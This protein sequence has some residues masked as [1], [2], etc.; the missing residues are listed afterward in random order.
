MGEISSLAIFPVF[1]DFIS[2]ETIIS[3]PRTTVTFTI[4]LPPEMAGELE[5]TMRREHRT[6]SELIREALRRYCAA[7]P[8]STGTSPH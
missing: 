7:L 3:M 4:S 1:S 8:P 5:E 2:H 6:R